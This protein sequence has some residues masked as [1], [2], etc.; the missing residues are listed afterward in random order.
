[1]AIDPEAPAARQPVD[2]A[3][4]N[5]LLASDLPRV[6]AAYDE[7]KSEFDQPEQVRAR[8]VLI[9][10]A[11]A[12]RPTRP[13]AEAE[14][15]AARRRRPGS[16]AARPSRRSRRRSPRTPARRT[17]G[18]DLGFFS[19][20]RMVPAFEEAAFSLEPGALS[21]PVKTPLRLPRDPGGGEAPGE[22][23]SPSTRRSAALARTILLDEKAGAA[24][25]ALVEKLLAAVRE[26]RALVDAARERG[27][28]LERPDPL[29]RRGR[30][31]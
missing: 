30:T 10:I 29:R 28:T 9:R 15:G 17:R 21:E 12:G 22:G 2:D 8:H 31:G 20:G 25:D 14:A 7:R 26:G 18:G 24:A 4:V 1:M 23:R 13:R 27:L 6:Q 3:A 11:P 5:A 19:R 16:A